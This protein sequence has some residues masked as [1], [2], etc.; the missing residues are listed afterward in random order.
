VPGKGVALLPHG[1][2]V[3]EARFW[4]AVAGKR[5]LAKRL[6]QRVS[7]IEQKQLKTY[8]E[9]RQRLQQTDQR[10]ADLSNKAKATA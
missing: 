3:P 2:G 10:L 1:E 4:R 6:F 9:T 8:L 5:T 7:E